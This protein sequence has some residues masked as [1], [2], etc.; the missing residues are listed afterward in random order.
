[1]ERRRFITLVGGAAA[2]WPLRVR[3]QQAA[4][5][6]IGVLAAPTEAS[7]GPYIDAF[8]KGL[9]ETGY[10]EGQNVAI[11]Y[12]WA[13]GQYDRLPAMATDLVARQVAV[14]VTIGGIPAALAAKAATSTI[15]I[16]FGVAEDPVKVGLVDSLARPNGN[17]TGVSLLSVELEWK[18]LELIREVMPQAASIAI[19]LNPKNPQTA[20]QLPEKTKAAKALGLQLSVLNPSS[21]AEIDS[22]FSAAAQQHVSALV[23]GADSFFHGRREHLVEL[24]ARY[25]LPTIYPYREEAAIGGLM[26]YGINLAG[27][28]YLEGDYAG[29]VLK[30]SRPAELPVQQSTSVEL[31]INL[32]TAKTL[33]LSFPLALLGRTDEVIE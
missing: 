16:V 1:M 12:R 3:A 33:G 25:A 27:A 23:I 8:R 22:A 31:V 28:Y 9:K 10:T 15:P 13:E 24:A 7:Y 6:V 30:G 21:D 32:K 5:P 14:M 29:R 20:A 11:E 26:S 18:R 19:L 2:A 17:A 4:M